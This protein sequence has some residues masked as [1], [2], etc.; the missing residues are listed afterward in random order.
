MVL[1]NRYKARASRRYQAQRG[2]SSSSS[3]GRGGSHGHPNDRPQE[4]EE[5]EEHTGSEEDGSD[6]EAKANR[7]KYARRKMQSNDWRFDHG[8]EEEEDPGEFRATEKSIQ[9]RV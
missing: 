9:A 2:G 5:A 6:E 1:Q 4:D 7:A 3:R 8:S